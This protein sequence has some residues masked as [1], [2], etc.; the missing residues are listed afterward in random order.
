MHSSAGSCSIR[1]YK[2]LCGKRTAEIKELYSV[3]ALTGVARSRGL[4]V[5]AERD[6]LAPQV[7]IRFSVLVTS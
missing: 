5:L 7:R 3:M 4:T 6:R 2:L 1:K